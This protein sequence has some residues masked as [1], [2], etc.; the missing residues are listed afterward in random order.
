M[1]SDVF[2][3]TPREVNGDVE[4]YGVVFLEAGACRLPVIGSRSYGVIDA[5]DDEKTEFLVPSDDPRS[6]AEKIELLYCDEEL[7]R[8]PGLNGRKKSRIT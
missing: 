7:R 4:G 1:A 3:L 8:E 6:L 5:V 2:Y